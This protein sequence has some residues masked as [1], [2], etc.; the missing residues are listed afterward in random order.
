MSFKSKD[1]VPQGNLWASFS[2]GSLDLGVD[3]EAKELTACRV[4]RAL[5]GLGDSWVD[6]RASLFLEIVG[7]HA[8]DG[9]SSELGVLVKAADDFAP[10]GAQMIAV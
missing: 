4:E 1:L 3:E 6:E 10:Q 7:E 9:A 2:D 8:F 5:L